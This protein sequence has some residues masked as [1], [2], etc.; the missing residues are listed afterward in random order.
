MFPL[1]QTSFSKMSTFHVWRGGL[2]RFFFPY[3]IN[4]FA[5]DSLSLFR[6]CAIKLIGIS[7]I[8]IELILLLYQSCQK[9]SS[10]HFKCTKSCSH[11]PQCTVETQLGEVHCTADLLFDSF[12]FFQTSEAD[13][14]STWAKQLNTKNKQE[15]SWEGILPF[16]LVFSVQHATAIPQSQDIF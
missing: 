7:L 2:V 11:W 13:A 15:V 9:N 12:G 3:L 10:I 6:S 8:M 14:N 16:K 4:Y 5:F 1:C